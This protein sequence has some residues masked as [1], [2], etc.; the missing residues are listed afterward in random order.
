MI[1]LVV[2]EDQT[3]VLGALVA[4][5][6]LEEDIEVVGRATNGD[7]ALALVRALDP[8]LLVTDIEMPGRSGLD[9]AQLLKEEGRRTRVLI[10]TTFGRPGY[11]RR[12][13]E[14]GVRGYLLKDAPSEQLADAV[15]RIAAGQRA[16]D[17]ALADSA[18]DYEDPL[19]DRER[20]VLRLS[21]H[22]NSSKQ[23]AAIL[24]LSPGTVRNYLHEA[25]QKLGAGNRIDAVRVARQNGWL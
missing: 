7:A 8:D 15:R 6:D 10:V 17:P 1:R 16:I 13:L 24:G 19:N 18:W 20:E 11:L 21:E 5:L 4:L 9:L 12:A 14:A 23:I 3:M 25:A 22:G 2:A